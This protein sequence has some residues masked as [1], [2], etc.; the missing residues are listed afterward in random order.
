MFEAD[1]S[2]VEHRSIEANGEACSNLGF[3]IG[4]GSMGG[5]TPSIELCGS[6]DVFLR[7]NSKTESEILRTMK[8]ASHTFEGDKVLIST[9]LCAGRESVDGEC[10]VRARTKGIKEHADT[11]LKIMRLHAW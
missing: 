4:Q 3:A 6:V 10:D 11:L 9:L 7:T 1:R 5:I 8:I 2:G